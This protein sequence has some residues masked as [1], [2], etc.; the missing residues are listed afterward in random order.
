MIFWIKRFALN[1]L[2]SLN[3]IIEKLRLETFLIVPL[4]ALSQVVGVIVVEPPSNSLTLAKRKIPLLSNLASEIAAVILARRF[5]LK[6]AEADKMRMAGMLASGVAH[7]FN[8]LLQ[9][10]M[11]QASLI[12][13][14]LS[15]DS[16]LVKSARMIIEAAGKG[17]SLISQLLS[18]SV[19][20]ARKLVESSVDR[21]I[22]SS[23]DL[24]K[25]AIG[26]EIDLSVDISSSLAH[27]S[28][29]FGQFQQ[30]ISNVL[31]NAK[32]A[33][34]DK[35]GGKIKIT[36]SEVNLKSGE[37]DPELAPGHYVRI[38]I[39]DNGIGMD[40]EAQT[41]CF[42]P[43]FSSKNRDGQSGISFSG[44]GLG[45]S[46]AYSIMKQHDGLLAVTSKLGEGTTFRLYFPVVSKVLSTFI[47]DSEKQIGKSITA[48]VLLYDLDDVI[49]NTIKPI[50]SSQGLKCISS[51]LVN[52]AK[53]AIRRN[54][55]KINAIIVDVDS[56]GYEMLDFI[57]SINKTFEDI[58]VLIVTSDSRRWLRL[59]EDYQRI[60]VASKPIGVWGIHALSKR[61]IDFR[62]SLTDSA[63]KDGAIKAESLI[64]EKEV[65]KDNGVVPNIN[66]TEDLLPS[67]TTSK[68]EM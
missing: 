59:F 37:I 26:S 44:S 2:L 7:N 43:F 14:Q 47:N 58:L 1:N 5:E 21:L 41:R 45:L 12:E 53:E 35:Q 30:V 29:D 11:G 24:Y 25:S 38:D 17:A 61:I 31:V 63:L 8:N 9:A 65:I 33:I 46:S 23:L 42:E 60:H 15:K 51:K 50:F 48:D 67:D 27:I 57:R 22:Y 54:I 55:G 68:E 28:V 13:L 19:H 52:E 3:F 16:P 62:Q 66:N 56:S 36:A 4:V 39:E 18:F 64:I 20:D 34:G 49:E 6:M 40:I 10:V 32:E